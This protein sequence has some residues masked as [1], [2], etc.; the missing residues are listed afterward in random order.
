M[1]R[2]NRT[3]KMVEVSNDF[4]RMASQKGFEPPTSGLGGLRSIQ[5]SY[6]DL[7]EM[8]LSLTI[9]HYDVVKNLYPRGFR[10]INARLG[11]ARSIQVSYGGIFTF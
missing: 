2:E 5:L 9:T 7:C 11:G 10:A 4:H 8:S 1:N 3:I 6:W